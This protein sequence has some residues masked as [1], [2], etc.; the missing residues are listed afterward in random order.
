MPKS[1]SRKRRAQPRPTAHTQPAKSP[2]GNTTTRDTRFTRMNL[3]TDYRRRRRAGPD[4]FD[5]WLTGTWTVRRAGVALVL[6][7]CATAALAIALLVNLHEQDLFDNAPYC[8]SATE[9]NCEQVLTATIQDRGEIRGGSKSAPVYY[10]DLTGP[11]PADGRFDLPEESDLWGGAA[12]G[13]TVT[14]YAWHG[15]VVRI[16]DGSVAGDTDN[17]PAVGITRLAALLASA[18]V[19]SLAFAILLIRIVQV[20]HGHKHGWSRKLVPF[21]FFA[22]C[23]ALFF[24]VGAIV[25]SQ[26]ES[27]PISLL[28]GAGLTSIAAIYVLVI[29]LRTR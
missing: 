29:W 9:T 28:G 21:N 17:A 4:D 13:D 1:K 26:F 8:L 10:L 7:I 24:P 19:C 18:G 2:A 11:Q 27:I 12:S 3:G 25:G 16:L 5:A 15:A 6:A 14:A 20:S 23:A 22:M